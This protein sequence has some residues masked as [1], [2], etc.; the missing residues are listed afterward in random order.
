MR[1]SG[2]PASAHESVKRISRRVENL[3]ERSCQ[4]CKALV[5]VACQNCQ[6]APIVTSRLWLMK[7]SVV[8]P[9][10]RNDV[11]P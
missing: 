4:N 6:A 8:V 7:P 2:K 3:L 10:G 11:N 9:L 1:A 5:R